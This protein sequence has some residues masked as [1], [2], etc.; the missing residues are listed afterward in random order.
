MQE[1]ETESIKLKAKFDPKSF[2]NSFLLNTP[3]L[4]LF[5]EKTRG[6]YTLKDL[7]E[8]LD[9]KAHQEEALMVFYLYLLD[10]NQNALA[11]KFQHDFSFRL[12]KQDFLMLDSIHQIENNKDPVLFNRAIKQ[13]LAINDKTST[14]FDLHWLFNRCTESYLMSESP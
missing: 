5:K 3:D 13:I 4:A 9:G 12:K 7:I 14:A 8:L 1:F 6:A 11:K 2:V 10:L